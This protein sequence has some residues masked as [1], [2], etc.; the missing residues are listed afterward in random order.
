LSHSYL[1]TNTLPRQARDKHGR[2][3]KKDRFSSGGTDPAR[4]SRHAERLRQ[5][6]RCLAAA[7]GYSMALAAGHTAPGWCLNQHGTCLGTAGLL[8]TKRVVTALCL[9]LNESRLR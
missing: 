9:L 4:L 1:K 5:E 6:G 3:S 8:G 2:N 7:A